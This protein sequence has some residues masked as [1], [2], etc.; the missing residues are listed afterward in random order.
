MMASKDMT[1][2]AANATT[3]V[4][5]SAAELGQAEINNDNA[6]LI[7]AIAALTA[8]SG[9]GTSAPTTSGGQ[10]IELVVNLDGK[11]VYRR[12]KPRLARDLRGAGA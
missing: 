7:K 2:E 4:M 9:Q 8:A 5:K 6:E 10:K 12:L 1:P 3:Q 11:E